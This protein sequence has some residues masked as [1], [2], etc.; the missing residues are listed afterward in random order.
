[1]APG[2]LRGLQRLLNPLEPEQVK[3][4]EEEVPDVRNL[5]QCPLRCPV[6]VIGTLSMVTVNPAGSHRW[7]EAELDDG[8]GQV[9]LVWM[10]RRTLAGIDA[11]RRVRVDGVITID[12]GRRVI[13]NPKY[14]LL[15]P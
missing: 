5:D 2:L 3:E 6:R 13:Y 1:M 11:G 7:L 8:T 10:G 12:K 9:L 4:G 14:E 15:G